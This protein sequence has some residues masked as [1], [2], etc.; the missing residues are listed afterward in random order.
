VALE[1]EVL[2]NYW[3]AL[4][5][6]YYKITT[7]RIL[8]SPLRSLILKILVCYS[9]ATTSGLWV[10][11]SKMTSCFKFAQI[12]IFRCWARC[13]YTVTPLRRTWPR[14][15]KIKNKNQENLNFL[16]LTFKFWIKKNSLLERK[17]CLTI[18]AC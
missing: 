3:F 14:A 17:P 4:R 18:A 9:N 7:I 10:R 13:G 2:T 1:S 8:M 6:I 11:L 5:C 15:W 16:I 12:Y